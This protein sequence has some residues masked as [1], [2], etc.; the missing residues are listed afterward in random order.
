VLA[1]LLVG[2]VTVSGCGSG[3]GSGDVNVQFTRPDGS[4]ASFPDTVRAWCAPFDEDNPEVEAVHVFAGELPEGQSPDPFWT[5]RAV[6]ADIE[7]DPATVLPNGFVH[8]E[9]KGAALFALDD[10]A[11]RHNELSSQDEE[12][13]GVIRVRLD[14]CDP[15]DTV[16][17]ELDGVTLGAELHGAPSLAVEGTADAEIE[18]AP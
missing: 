8:D 18:A 15:G 16:R 7:R 10:A 12:S 1:T 5:L 17:L 2:V 13:E 4:I 3:E 14:G 11:H 6:R 9:P